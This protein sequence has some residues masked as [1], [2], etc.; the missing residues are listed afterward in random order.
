MLENAVHNESVFGFLARKLHFEAT[1]SGDWGRLVG[2]EKGRGS[3]A[4]IMMVYM[5]PT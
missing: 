3:L 2:F 1:K 5:Q 4:L